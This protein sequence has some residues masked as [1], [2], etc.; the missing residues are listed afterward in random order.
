MDFRKK[1]NET[2]VRRSFESKRES[3]SGIENK[4]AT[5]L[6]LTWKEKLK[7]Y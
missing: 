6:R 2:K 5:K 4:L 7:E 1:K 3:E